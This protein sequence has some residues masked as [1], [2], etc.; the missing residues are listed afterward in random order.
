LHRALPLGAADAAAEVLL[1]DDVGRVLGPALGELHVA[2]LER[3]L[4]RVADHRV[5]DLPFEL[6]EGM[7]ALAREAPFDGQP[8]IAGADAV[9]R[10]GGIRGTGHLSTPR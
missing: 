3:R 7:D 5:P 2:L 1:R 10:F 9:S 8:L 4:G 6:V